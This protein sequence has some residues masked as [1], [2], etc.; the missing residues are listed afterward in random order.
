MIGT[1]LSQITD[2]V[3]R[4]KKVYVI[5][6]DT[7]NVE[8]RQAIFQP[9]TADAARLAAKLMLSAI[10]KKGKVLIFEG[11]ME[12]S[13]ARIRSEAFQEYMADHKQIEILTEPGELDPNEAYKQTLEYLKEHPDV[14][15]IYVTT[16]TPAN[17]AQAVEDSGLKIKMVVYDHSQE[18]FRF[19]KKDVIVSAIGQDP[20]GQGHDPVIW[21][22]NS[23]VTGE[24]LPSEF[25]SCRAK[26][27]DKTNVDNLLEV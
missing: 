27:V 24:A 13:Q 16:G 8:L 25:M 3:A 14:N 10:G 21:M 2:V 26:I 22:Y 17:I 12:V 19:I 18:F 11:S 23:L 5:N 9:D 1:V 6:N 4:G 15:G 20:F 7:T